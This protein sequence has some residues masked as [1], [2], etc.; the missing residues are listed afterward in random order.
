MGEN[1]K[2]YGV[3]FCGASFIAHNALKSS[4][5]YAKKEDEDSGNRPNYVI[6]AAGSGEGRSGIP[7]A[8]VISLIDSASN[9]LSDQDGSLHVVVHDGTLRVFKWPTMAL[10]LDAPKAHTSVKK[11]SPDGKYRVSVG[12]GPGTVWDISSSIAKASLSKEN[13]EV[14]EFCKFSLNGESDPFLYVTAMRG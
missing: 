12:S 6:F 2:K 7:N 10:V 4:G 9:S 8:L 3:P 13:D 14:F 5:T 1:C 11:I